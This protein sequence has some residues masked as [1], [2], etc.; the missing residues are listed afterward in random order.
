MSLDE[1][2]YNILCTLIFYMYMT[3]AFD[4]SNLASSKPCLLFS[5]CFIFTNINYIL[6]E[7]DARM[8]CMF[9]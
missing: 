2:G 4:F 1:I 6:H 3:Q 9:G 5:F 8:K 7:E